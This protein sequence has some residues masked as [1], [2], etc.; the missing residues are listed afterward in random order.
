MRHLLT[1]ALAVACFLPAARGAEQVDGAGMARVVEPCLDDTALLVA[2][3][4][5][6][7]LDLGPVRK[8]IEGMF[9]RVDVPREH[10]AQVL[11]GVGPAFEAANQWLAE[12]KKAGG[13][14]AYLV[15]N[16]SNLPESPLVGVIPLR[17]GADVAA[18]TRLVRPVVQGLEDELTFE[19]RGGALVW[20]GKLAIARLN[21]IKP[22]AR[23]ELV[24]ALEAAGDPGVAVRVV[25]APSAQTRR[26]LAEMLPKLPPQ[27]VG[28]VNDPMMRH[29]SW[30]G[31]GIATS[32][33]VGLRAV[34]Q[35]PD[36]ASAA[37][38][39]KMVNGLIGAGRQ[40]V[41]GAMGNDPN[42]AKVGAELERMAAALA[43]KVE[44]DR[45]ALR[46]AAE[47][48]LAASALIFPAV[49]KAQLGAAQ[50]QSASQMR[51]ILQYCLLYANEHKGQY[52]P[53]LQ[54]LSK[55]GDMPAGLLAHPGG[56]RF[57]YG[58]LKP[59][60]GNAA[61]GDQVVIYERS[62]VG[63]L[64]RV[65]VGFGDGHVEAIEPARFEKLLT[66][67]RARNEPKR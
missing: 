37:T 66:E 7:R 3:V 33:D 29:V 11:A 63:P 36:A 44:G 40:A 18:L 39:G 10:K 25:F 48:T 4:D 34:V 41:V 45:V 61:T 5:F 24:S 27:L 64:E 43:P 56:E 19:T 17:A 1:V 6:G 62:A 58:Y 67:S 57:T 28:G 32:P 12:F 54:E 14:E 13:A 20:G 42:A 60:A 38:V 47:Q 8:A 51:M 52:P 49:A 15:V 55:A 65:N 2:H 50:V 21:E 26:V 22:Q 35:S 30:V 9:Q 16:A 23:P 59:A 31:V 46:L 53:D